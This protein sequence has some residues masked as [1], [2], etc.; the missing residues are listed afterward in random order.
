[1][2]GNKMGVGLTSGGLPLVT[3]T[4]DVR[5]DDE[6]GL[7]RLTDD[8]L[9]FYRSGPD[10]RAAIMSM[11]ISGRSGVVEITRYN[12]KTEAKKARDKLS[13]KEKER[14]LI[15]AVEPKYS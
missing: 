5:P 8:G 2:A 15:R 4:E 3:I 10:F 1:M 7:F 6:W 13:E 9:E 11:E 14:T 12:T